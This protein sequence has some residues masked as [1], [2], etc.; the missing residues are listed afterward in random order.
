MN[1]K[2]IRRG[3]VVSMIVLF[4]LL[5]TIHFC[6]PTLPIRSEDTVHSTLTAASTKSLALFPASLQTISDEALAGTAIEVAV[7]NDELLYIGGQLFE[8]AALLKDVFVQAKTEFIGNDA[9][10]IGTLLHGAA[11][12]YAQQWAEANGYHYVVDDSAFTAK[13]PEATPLLT[14][15]FFFWAYIP[16]DKRRSSLLRRLHQVFV[17]SM[18]PQDRPELAPIDYRFP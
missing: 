3:F 14:I 15:P 10:P 8:N 12:T 18:R 5:F 11:G 7:F 13:S 1:T 2:K 17:K 16:D 6:V 4:S 9:F